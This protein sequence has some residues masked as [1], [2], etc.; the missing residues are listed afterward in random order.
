MEAM[1]DE[2]FAVHAKKLR[3]EQ[4]AAYR[5]AD[6]RPT[7]GF[8]G[9]AAAFLRRSDDIKKWSL[10]NPEKQRRIDLA[11]AAV[12]AIKA[13]EER[14]RKKLEKQRWALSTLDEVPRIKALVAAGGLDKTKAVDAI[15]DWS[16]ANSWCLLL[17]GGVG[18][19]KSTA[20]AEY[21]VEFAVHCDAKPLWVRAVEASRMSAFG[22]QAEARFSAWRRAALLI[23]DDLGTEMMTATW[24]QALDDVMDFRYQ[25]ALPTILPSNL[26]AEEFKARYGERISDRIRHDG[27]V[28]SI[29]TKSMRRK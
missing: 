18:S 12:D 15:T 19:G 22:E 9:G 23:I 20:A 26:T 2:A 11:N 8:E 25:H 13:E 21:A 5:A 7:S 14:R 4:E 29:D 3:D 28:R 17:L 24:Q 27:T 10:A 16:R 6:D 1:S